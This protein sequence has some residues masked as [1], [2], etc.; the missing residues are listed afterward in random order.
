MNEVIVQDNRYPEWMKAWNAK[1]A[2]IDEQLISYCSATTEQTSEAMD[3]IG[4]QLQGWWDKQH[5]DDITKAE[6]EKAKADSV[7]FKAQVEN[8]IAHLV[9][10]GKIIIA[11]HAAKA[12]AVKTDAPKWR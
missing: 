1:T 12:D 8:R 2:E 4:L 3:N 11:K 5:L 9:Q 7:L 6:Y 10:D